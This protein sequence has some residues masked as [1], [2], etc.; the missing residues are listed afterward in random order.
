MTLTSGLGLRPL[1][2]LKTVANSTCCG[3]NDGIGMGVGVGGTA[4]AGA[5]AGCSAGSS[6]D[7]AGFSDGSSAGAGAGAGCSDGS[8]ADSVRCSTSGSDDASSSAS[9]ASSS[10]LRDEVGVAGGVGICVPFSSRQQ[11][12]SV[13]N[14]M[15]CNGLGCVQLISLKLHNKNKNKY[16]KKV[17]LFAV[18]ILKTAPSYD[19]SLKKYSLSKSE[20]AIICSRA[21]ARSPSLKLKIDISPK[22]NVVE[23][24]GFDHSEHN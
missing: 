16:E 15:T 17:G 3:D 4:G 20:R 1:N 12:P 11:N 18:R 9:P 24:R 13:I 23:G 5:G 21:R 19:D 10:D 14:D 22:R 6:A 2:A 7:S 8:S